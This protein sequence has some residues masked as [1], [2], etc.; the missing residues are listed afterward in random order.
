[1]LC[2]ELQEHLT[3]DPL[4]MLRE[5]HRVMRRDA[6]LVLTTPN[7]ASLQNILHLVHGRNVHHPKRLHHD[8]H[9]GY[10]GEDLGDES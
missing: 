3:A 8:E 10:Q 9:E 5:I 7:V 4:A 2:C 1:M 6:W